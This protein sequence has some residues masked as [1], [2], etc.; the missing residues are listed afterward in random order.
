M[1]NLIMPK[2][3]SQM[4]RFIYSIKIFYDSYNNDDKD[5][6]NIIFKQKMMEYFQSLRE[7]N[8]GAKIVKQSEMCIWQVKNTT[9]GS[10][11]Y[12]TCQIYVLF[13]CRFIDSLSL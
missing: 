5:V 10:E 2:Q 1:G 8:D 3:T 4:D 7:N 11:K 12:N 6:K 9:F 13:C